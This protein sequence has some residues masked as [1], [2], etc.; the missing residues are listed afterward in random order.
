MILMQT[1]GYM[2]SSELEFLLAITDKDGDG[3]VEYLSFLQ[4]YDAR[5]PNCKEVELATW[6]P[7]TPASPSNCY[8]S[9]APD[10]VQAVL[11]ERVRIRLKASQI[12]IQ[13]IL[14]IFC[15][16]RNNTISL[17][18]LG[19]VL[20]Y[21]P[22]RLSLVEARCLA[23][24]IIKGQ[25]SLSIALVEKKL[26]VGVSSEALDELYA[27][28]ATRVGPRILE[29]CPFSLG[30]SDYI[31][32]QQFRKCLSMASLTRE[33]EEQCLLVTDKNSQGRIRWDDFVKK[34]SSNRVTPKSPSK[35][36]PVST[37]YGGCC[38]FSK[39]RRYVQ[40]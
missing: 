30:A 3:N 4:R 8:P 31:T 24:T 29:T 6:F 1:E 25:S 22:F 26:A 9:L 18:M 21:L 28:V 35:V 20:G 27:L 2:T 14:P 11:I 13:E 15:P 17:D 39:S 32:Q 36:G 12:S 37:E 5:M 7:E 34:A 33:E 40:A 10:Q 19:K 23:N 38:G 16:T